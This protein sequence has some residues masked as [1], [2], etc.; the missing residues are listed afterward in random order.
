MYI[1]IQK[2]VRVWGVGETPKRAIEEA[3]DHGMGEF[4][5]PDIILRPCTI[6]AWRLFINNN[7]YPEL[8][9]QDL[10]ELPD[11]TF[12]KSGEEAS[13]QGL[14]SELEEQ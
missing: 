9:L 1:V 7:L 11:G 13:L 2:G 8:V 14:G 6:R 12:C 5:V 10:V 3:A 4:P